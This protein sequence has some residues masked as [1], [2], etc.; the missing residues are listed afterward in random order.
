MSGGS[1]MVSVISF[2]KNLPL[3]QEFKST[4]DGADILGRGVHG[5][6]RFKLFKKRYKSFFCLFLF[7]S[8]FNENISN[9][10]N[11]ISRKM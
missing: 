9:Q 2:G 7:F 6:K 5:A 11:F 1:M 3:W 4:D 10:L 8:H